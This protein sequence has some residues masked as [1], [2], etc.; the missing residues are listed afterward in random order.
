MFE[1]ALQLMTIGLDD[2]TRKML[3]DLFPASEFFHIFDMTG[4]EQFLEAP[5][6]KLFHLI[7]C[8][9]GLTELP[10]NELAQTARMQYA[11]SG[12]FYLTWSREGYERKTFIKNG[13]DDSFLLP[14]D[15]HTLVAKV[16]EILAK[17]KDV[18]IKVFRS[19]KIVDVQADTKLN[20]DVS[21]FLPVNKK[22]IKMVAAGDELDQQHVDKLQTHNVSSI[23][24]PL[25]QMGEFYK[26]TAE[27]LSALGEASDKLSETERKERLGSSVRDIFSSV[28]NVSAQE[29]TIQEGKSIVT[30]CEKIVENYILAKDPGDWYQ[31]L[32]RAISTETSDSYSHATNVST[33]AALFAI[34]LGI[35]RPADL[36]IAGLFHDIGLTDI[37][38][39]IAKKRESEMTESEKKQYRMHPELSVKIMKEKKLIVPPVVQQAVLQHHERFNGTGFPKGMTGNKI[40]I[41]AQLVA[42]ADEFDYLTH[43]EPGK[44]GLSPDDA[45]RQMRTANG[46]DS[47]LLD[48]VINLLPKLGAPEKS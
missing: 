15:E 30:D 23:Y 35:G 28:F 1:Q 14:L 4:F 39:A 22:Y 8:G 19:V 42:L 34:G 32:T 26:Y 48:K 2:R 25:E 45:I 5:P 7:F 29:A 9:T 33:F 41:E 36:A 16:E 40:C 31:K 46:F 24:V 17:L 27:R 21:I 13:F 3:A 38:Q 6:T 20:F 11:Q 18:K 10:P 37:D 12:I 47:A 44:K 43:T